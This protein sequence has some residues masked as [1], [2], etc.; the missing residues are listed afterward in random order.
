MSPAQLRDPDP[1]QDRP[2]CPAQRPR[3]TAVGRHHRRAAATMASP[4]PSISHARERRCWCSRRGSGSAA[5]APSRRPGPVTGSLPAPT[6]WACCT[7]WS[8]KNWSWPG[9]ATAGLRRAAATSCPFDDGSSI[10]LWDDEAKA[11]AEL[12]RFSPRDVEGRHEMHR[13]MHRVCDAIRPLGER[14]TWL[15][16]APDPGA[17]RGAAGP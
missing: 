16:R 6:W 2:A 7:R 9:A 13:L 3:L 17:T 1:R 11:E 5:P 4:A 10:Q 15:G 8:S 14:D 12:Q